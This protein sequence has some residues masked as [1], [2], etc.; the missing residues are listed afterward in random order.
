MLL[1]RQGGLCRIE[2]GFLRSG[3]DFLRRLLQKGKHGGE[4]LLR[5]GGDGFLRRWWRVP[6]DPVDASKEFN[7][8]QRPTLRLLD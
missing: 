7:T 2:G 6:K 4:P 8:P 1:R 3:G 5:N